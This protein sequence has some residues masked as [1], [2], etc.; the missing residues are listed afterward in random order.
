MKKLLTIV[1]LVLAMLVLISCTIHGPTIIGQTAEKY[2]DDL[3]YPFTTT[4]TCIFATPF[5]TMFR[6][7]LRQTDSNITG[8]YYSIVIYYVGSS[9][10]FMDGD[11]R[12]QTDST[13]YKCS[14]STPHRMVLYGGNVLETISAT[15]DSWIIKDM[16]N[17]N[18]IRIQFF[19]SPITITKS[20]K[21]A[22]NNFYNEFVVK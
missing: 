20:G 4:E 19:G 12:I 5:T 16:A 17:S 22:I 7:S 2:Y 18:E 14:D 9:W 21:Q 11:V 10:L 15:I 3:E 13:L 8:I 6:V 1:M